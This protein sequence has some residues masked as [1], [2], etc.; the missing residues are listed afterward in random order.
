MGI[1]YTKEQRQVIELRNRN[2]L[3]SAAAG[4][5]KTA[6]L[7][8]RIITR[9]TRDESPI[10]V[11]QLLIVTYTDAAASEM[12]ERIHNAIEKALEKEPDNTHLQK[13]STL[14]HQAKITT[15]HRFCLS[16]IREHFHK[17]DLDPGF[18][19]AD[20]AELKL[21]KQDAVE[22]VLEEAY[23]KEDNSFLHFVECYSSGKDD[24]NLEEWILKLYEFSR[25][26]PNPQKWLESC[27]EQ[28]HIGD[29]EEFQKKPYIAEAVREIKRYVKDM[30]EL[31]ECA[32]ALCE[33]ED[34]PKAYEDALKSDWM[35]LQR[36]SHMNRFEEL[37]NELRN[38]QWVK[39]G[40]V[41]KKETSE[42]WI[43]RVKA[44]RDD[45]KTMI[46]SL[47]DKY[48]FTSLEDMREEM[49]ACEERIAVL[50][51]LVCQFEEKFRKNK[52]EKNVIDFS[53]MEQF[54]L[55][56]LVNEVNDQYVPT[57][58]AKEYQEQFEEI[59]I[60]EYQDSNYVQ[61]AILNSV[62]GISKGKYNVFMVGD[63]K[64]SIYRFRLSR[65]ELFMEKFN[66]YSTDHGP[67][68]RIDLHK[69]FR[70]RKEVL[71]ST[72][73]IFEQIM[74]DDLGGI[75]YDENAAL[76]VGA[77]YEEQIGSETEILCVE[78][79][80][81]SGKDKIEIEAICVSKE[82]K[83]LTKEHRIID[84]E[85]KEFRKVQFSDIAILT[86]SLK[87]W[88]DGFRNILR[89]E[90]IPSFSASKEGY[91]KT[92]EIQLLLNYLRMVDNPRQDLPFTAVLK[93]I[94]ANVT[95]NELATLRAEN[96]ET[97]MY[98][99]I[100][101]YIHEGTDKN[102]VDKLKRFIN[103]L[104]QVRSKVPYTGI[105]ALLQHIL[106]ITGYLQYV[107]ALP[108]GEQRIANIEM[109]LE[110]AVAFE[111][112]SYK[113]LFHFVRYI[114]Q[115]Q[116]YDVDYGEAGIMEEQA[117]VVSIMS[118]H[119]SK[120]L[121][122]PIVFVV[123]MGK[124]FNTQ[125]LRNAMVI[126]PELGIGVDYVDPILR[127]KETT[128]LKK[129]IQHKL[130]LESVAEE[131]RVLYVAMTRAK[132][133]LILTGVLNDLQEKMDKYAY[134]HMRTEKELPYSALSS[135]KEYFDWVLPA[136]L[137]R[138]C[139]FLKIRTVTMDQLVKAELEEKV[140]F[141]MEKERLIDW[142][143]ERIYDKNTNNWLKEQFAYRYPQTELQ[144]MKPKVSV[145][146]LKAKKAEVQKKSKTK[147]PD[148]VEKISVIDGAKRGTLYHKIMEKL[149]FSLEYDEE[150]LHIAIAR[151]CEQGYMTKEEMLA[152]NEKDILRFLCSSMGTRLRDAAKKQ[153]LHM[154]QP[155]VLGIPAKE[156]YKDTNLD[157][158]LLV[159]GIV[160]VYF[161]E[162]DG[163]VLL[164]YK[165]DRT[166]KGEIL[167]K[168]YKEQLDYYGLALE[169][170]TQKRV[171]EKWIY[172]FDLQENIRVVE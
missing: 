67:K 136:C 104:E 119:K 74:T 154:E 132:E 166:E 61:E 33:E 65:P 20:E 32:I 23:L 14:I 131:L 73:H 57:S 24:R 108:D 160:D 89:T 100:M 87:G 113:G 45:I 64:Q 124:R 11:D 115:L 59:M 148:F 77:Q 63:V 168:K 52:R 111:G 30:I 103:Q 142:D 15:I 80:D 85:T 55:Q 54:A 141:Y 53:D 129:I 79:P 145:T 118:I 110:K 167:I 4:S 49:D 40:R 94:F 6:V 135:A 35:I 47:A 130:Q 19:V 26:Y 159:Q 105:Y 161:E 82:I 140:D 128:L 138:M 134:L 7:V 27:I 39:L 157:E 107:A 9:L 18:R 48:A 83:K 17:I 149:D 66:T 2:I 28:Y 165:T 69:N 127:V 171:K 12:R 117:N 13:Q 97:L 25:S 163:I 76:H 112:T 72:N 96:E 93:S 172:S 162:E 155:F 29:L 51:Q 44:I 21:M 170:L 34:G 71:E 152:I 22:Q 121:E 41:N 133:K 139:A 151:M 16:I 78:A 98:D 84:K 123:G 125:D 109:L 56:I 116:K 92:Q 143:T 43:E 86:R 144:K 114:D 91:F 8:E 102:L 75:V 1:Q 150:T 164:D 42:V 106:D 169:Q 126:H 31:A 46:N 90:G 158:T 88:A 147:I 60:D 50:N 81:I 37:Q 101:R 3:V 36:M 10:D 38:F 122:F 70:S 146:E 68:Q 5:G 95:E 62:S 156:V 137:R 99:N 58:V 120:G 153:L